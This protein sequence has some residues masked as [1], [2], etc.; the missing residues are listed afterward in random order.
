MDWSYIAG[1]FDGEGHVSLHQ[2][3]RGG[4]SMQRALTWYNSHLESLESMRDFMGCGS[5]GQKAGTNKPVYTLCITRR[6][7]LVPV[8]NELIPRLIVKR[9]AAERLLDFLGTVEDESPNFGN[10]AA[11][12]TEQLIQWYHDEGKSYSQIAK[13]LDVDA[14]AIAQAFRVRGIKARPAGGSFMHNMPKSEE[15]RRRMKE[16]RRKMWEDPEFR[17]AQL[18]NLEKG[19]AA[20]RAKRNTQA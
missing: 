9:D 15:T 2:M 3:N 12:S 16:S 1:Y 7:E 10:V 4:K 5:I 8:L 11:T 13:I 18:V 14:S 20:L 19:R 17:A 6:S